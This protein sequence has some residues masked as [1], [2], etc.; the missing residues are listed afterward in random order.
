VTEH[1]RRFSAQVALVTG[2]AHG[3]G[4]AIARRFHAEGA[5]VLALDVDGQALEQVA[6]EL[7]GSEPLVCDLAQP[8]AIAE[9]MKRVESS[10]GRVD[11]LVN[12]AGI[13]RS[14]HILSADYEHWRQV[15][16]I[17]LDAQFLICLALAPLMKARHAGV[18]IN[19]ASIQA[20]LSEPCGSAYGASKA[21][22]TAFTRGLAV[23]L[24]PAG[25]RVN[26]IAPGFIQTR[27]SLNAEGVDET[28]TAEF[29]DW[30][31][32][33]RKIPMARACLAAEVAGVA[34]FLASADA[35]YMTGQT[36]VVDGGLTV[37]F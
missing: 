24:A 5:H 23:D 26:A 27:M 12:N 31:V 35:S 8:A 14:R 19:I 15:F 32:Q 10:H 36:L 28:S 13:G 16:S 17:N 7:P 2:A 29:Q 1:L 25:I 20:M 22:I 33:R 9:A 37:T 18:I 4:Q 11:I 6:A 34:A 21:A 3:I 30:Y